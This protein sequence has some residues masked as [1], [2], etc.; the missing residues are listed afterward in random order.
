MSVWN[1]AESWGWP[2]KLLHWLVAL[3][4]TALLVV[5][6][7]MVWLVS[8]L[9]TKFQLYQTHKS[10]GL[11]V[12][13]LVLLRLGWRALNPAPRLPEGLAP[14][15][16]RAA[17]LTHKGFYLLL[18]AMP[19]SGWLMSAAS[20]LV[21]PTVV[22]VLFTLPHPIGPDPALFAVLQ[23]VHAVLAVLLVVLLVLH[24]GAAAKHHLVYRDDV[25]AR[26]LPGAGRRA[27]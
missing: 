23:T 4:V 24:V 11:L 7:T 2:A 27:G 14:W 18:I 20:P 13:A 21:V 1:T 5:G 22:F 6:F 15:E 17:G 9:G 12:L 8:E 25:L 3:L 10:V 16:R 19:V 26:M